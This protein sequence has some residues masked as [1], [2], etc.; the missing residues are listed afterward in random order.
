MIHLIRFCRPDKLQES[1]KEIYSR[2]KQVSTSHFKA[3]ALE[4]KNVDPHQYQKAFGGGVEE[5]VEAVQFYKY[6]ETGNVMS[7]DELK[8]EYFEFSVKKSEN[9]EDTEE[10][11]KLILL[12]TIVDFIL[13]LADFT[14]ELMRKNVNSI[15][16]GQLDECY[17]TLQL[18]R[19]IQVGFMSRC[20]LIV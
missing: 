18:C 12:F 8:N 9:A 2:L 16:C 3:I 10:E 17:K 4:L 20:F 14:G 15:T 11:E 19:E 7:F 13:G 1:L 5:F 6:I